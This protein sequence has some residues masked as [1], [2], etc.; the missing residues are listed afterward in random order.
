[1]RNPTVTSSSTATLFAALSTFSTVSLPSFLTTS[2]AVELPRFNA[3]L[4]SCCWYLWV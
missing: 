1:M 2:D 4:A 3:V